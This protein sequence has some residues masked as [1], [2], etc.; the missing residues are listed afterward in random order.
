M[1]FQ[2]TIPRRVALQQSSLPLH[3]PGA[4]RAEKVGESELENIKW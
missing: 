1:S 2:L 3:Q 4:S